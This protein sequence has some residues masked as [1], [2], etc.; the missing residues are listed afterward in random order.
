MGMASVAY[1]QP[2]ADYRREIGENQSYLKNILSSPA[3]YK[4]AKKRRF[5]VTVNMEIGSGVHCL[6]LEGKRE[7]ESRFMLKPEG[8]SYATKEGKEWKAANKGKTILAKADYESVLGMAESLAKLEWFDQ[9]QT[10]YRKF[11][12]LSIYWENKGIPCKGRLDR[13]VD[14]GSYTLIL[15]LKS[16][17]SVDPHTF[18]K[19]VVGSM[20]YIFQSGW[21][22]EAAINAYQKPA[23]FAFIG[24][25]RAEPWTTSIFEVS[26]EMMEEGFRQTSKALDI[27]SNCLR[28]NSWPGPEISYNMLE[29]PPWYFSPS[30]DTSHQD[31][32]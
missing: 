23:K 26:T 22:T 18:L 31:L 19:K 15:D 27:L 9:N 1:C 10:D 28:T 14:M 13:I 25:E 5:P 30:F 16:T 7:F 20:N 4:A 21:Y 3:H 2:D 32:F 6:A 29:L 12:E 24:I 8:I 11:N 17:D